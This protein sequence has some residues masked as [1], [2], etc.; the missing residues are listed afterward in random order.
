MAERQKDETIQKL[1]DSTEKRRQKIRK[2]R[3]QTE[4]MSRRK[5]FPANVGEFDI[6]I[7]EPKEVKEDSIYNELKKVQVLIP[8]LLIKM[9]KKK[10]AL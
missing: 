7:N 8:P 10:E 1:K 6:Q 3:I 5:L 2:E 9:Q 4:L